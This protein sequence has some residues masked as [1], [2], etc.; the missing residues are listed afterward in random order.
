MYDLN[1][2]KYKP[3]V[4]PRNKKYGNN[5]W[6]AKGPKVGLRDITLY[7]DLEF[8][9]WLVVETDPTVLTYCEQPI[10][11]PYVI[12]GRLHSTI[13]DMWILFKNGKEVFVEVKYEKELFAKSTKYERTN[14]QISAQ[15]EWCKQNGIIH[16]VRTERMIRKGPR[17]IENKLKM[18]MNILNHQKPSSITQVMG[19]IKSNG[20]SIGD[21]CKQLQGEVVPYDVILACQWLCY[22][23]VITTNFC[24]KV[25]GNEMEVWLSEQT[26]LT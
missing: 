15:R 10:E 1:K 20:I 11:I 13:F 26:P 24:E 22:E 2:P 18:F 6:M 3:I 19:C 4:V 23:G 5:Y 17:Y 9:H 7:S 14:R 16:E 21:I 8:D 12:N 25:W